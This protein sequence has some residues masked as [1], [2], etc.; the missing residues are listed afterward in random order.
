MA[1]FIVFGYFCFIYPQNPPKSLKSPLKTYI[2]PIV[3]LIVNHEETLWLNL[4]WV[5]F[6][7]SKDDSSEKNFVCETWEGGSISIVEVKRIIVKLV[8]GL[9]LNQKN[10]FRTF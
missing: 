5:R 10:S 8:L 9:E 4:L 7:Y 3:N 1:Y 6:N 2:N